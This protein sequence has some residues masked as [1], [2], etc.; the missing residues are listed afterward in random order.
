MS[1]QAI[2]GATFSEA[3]NKLRN[4]PRGRRWEILSGMLEGKS[5]EELATKLSISQGTVRKQIS[6]IC[7]TFGLTESSGRAKR[8]DLVALFAKFNPELILNSQS[9]ENSTITKGRVYLKDAPD[10]MTVYGRKEELETLQ[11]W[12]IK[13]RCKLVSILGMGGVGKTSLSVKL[14]KSDEI[15]S[16]F[17]TIIWCS[18]INNP[19]IENILEEILESIS[20]QRINH[21]NI[22]N[23]KEE[24]IVW[25]TS[26]IIY[27]LRASR[28]MII[29]DNFETVIPRNTSKE[30]LDNLE[31]SICS[32]PPYIFL[33]MQLATSQHKSCLVITSREQPETIDKV[34][35]INSPV[36]K[37]F[38][39]GLAEADIYEIFN[40]KGLS[41]PRSSDSI[42]KFYK[43]YGGNPLCLKILA[44]YIIDLFNGDI[45][46]FISHSSSDY[47]LFSGVEDLLDQQFNRLNKFEKSILYW[48]AINQE[49]VSIEQL[50]LDLVSKPGLSALVEGIKIL[51]NNSLIEVNSEG[52]KLQSVIKEYIITKL[53]KMV[54]REI[55]KEDFDFLFAFSLIKS[56][57]KDYIR[58]IQTRLILGPIADNLIDVVDIKTKLLKGL[59]SLR[60]DPLK[61]SGY[62]AGNI[63]N[64]LL[65]MGKDLS[66]L[67]FS[68]MTVWQAYLKGKELHNVNL[69][70]S[71]LTNSVF[72]QTFGTVLAVASIAEKDLWATGDTNNEIRLWN[73]SSQQIRSFIGHKNWVRSLTFSPNE[74]F[75]A[76]ASDDQTVKI[77]DIESSQC[78]HTLEGHKERVW[79]VAF[80]PNGKLLASA[81]EDKTIRI[82]DI[83]NGKSIK[84]LEEHTSW[85]RSVAFSPDGTI[86]ASG[87]ND[88]TVKLW[89]ISDDKVVKISKIKD[90]QDP[91]NLKD[92]DKQIR[93]I[94]FSPDGKLLATGGRHQ[95]IKLW[96]LETNDYTEL[97]E[98]DIWIRAIAFSPD[99]KT[100]ASGSD[101]GI[102]KL[103]KVETANC[104]HTLRGHSAK[105]WSLAFSCKGLT[106]ISSGDDQTVKLWDIA[107]GKCLKT[108]E[109]YNNWSWAVAFSKNSSLLASSN[110][111]KTVKIWNVKEH[112]LIKEL[113][114]H[115]KRP[116]SVA[117]HPG[118]KMLATGSDDE[119]IK[120]WDVENGICIHTL[121][122]HTN[123]VLSVA[124][125][126]EGKLLASGGDDKMVRIWNIETHQFR[127]LEGHSNWIWSVS[128]SHN[129]DIL[130]S[131][132][133]DKTIR[134]WDVKS[135][136]LLREL[137]GHESW[138]RAVAFSPDDKFLASTSEDKTVRL[139]NV[140]TGEKKRVGEHDHWVRTISFHP[141]GNIIASAG[142]SETI[143]LWD[144]NEKVNNGKELKDHTQRIWSVAFS[145]DGNLLA[146][147]SE[148]GS[149][150]L[151][152]FQERKIQELL[153]APRLYEGMNITSVKGLTDVEI[154]NLITL[155][156]H[157]NG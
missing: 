17:E 27:Y 21:S 117:F 142:E 14:A 92:S 111:D 23:E 66:D 30:K 22:P 149:I 4:L 110:E 153:K 40:D 85:I 16:E 108:L 89:S 29:L 125:S 71:D 67:D 13:D 24:K 116:R 132:S 2:S 112:K 46:K 69:A 135:G 10:D 137:V 152:N 83:E 96:N 130:A 61:R 63:L 107:N 73:G 56:T 7:E 105:I 47:T 122:G 91:E 150:A 54:V 154:G 121:R 106:L 59:I 58:E 37:L 155:G 34:E 134:I 115:T 97:E 18:L 102:I 55:R 145:P 124:F 78:V 53:I 148:D 51:N 70:G 19:P 81:S 20:N 129:G 109:G 28:Y 3:L 11:T 86:L 33:L 35:G 87:S 157:K 52:Y 74:K 104:I 62:A 139:W 156:A 151:W 84:I 114:G 44:S 49:V 9:I 119:T 57:S 120:L 75:I 36:R 45:D 101:D 31:E 82:W 48:L 64:L 123:R 100:L 88:K 126:P 141:K 103:W 25:I 12:L 146:S 133:E 65:Y 26:Q 32:Y 39:S 147:G 94:A 1:N 80:S 41:I 131:A 50:H 93:S 15:K 138:V 98:H 136:K 144:L 6:L 127:L 68:N 76:S 43:L 143:I 140:E 113:K 5:D 8:A 72:T 99:G 77:W 38:L 90:L 118:E 42:S 79:S 60:H 128:F 95:V